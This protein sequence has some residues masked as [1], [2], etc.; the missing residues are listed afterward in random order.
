MEGYNSNEKKIVQT[1]EKKEEELSEL[2][3]ELERLNFEN[4]IGNWA[5]VIASTHGVL[6][7][8]QKEA[9]AEIFKLGKKVHEL[10]PSNNQV[11]LI[12]EIIALENTI[13]NKLPEKISTFKSPV[14][15]YYISSVRPGICNFL[16]NKTYKNY[17]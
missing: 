8:D 3:N 7:T 15:C 10:K 11:Q 1:D 4:K 2:I 9:E 6:F 16:R 17:K 5:I 13:N 14:N 12:K